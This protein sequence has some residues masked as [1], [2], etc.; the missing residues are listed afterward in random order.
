MSA[1]PGQD[2]A[3]GDT[4]GSMEFS[5]GGEEADAFFPVKVAFVGVG[6]M[7]GL[8]VFLGR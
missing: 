3:P 2:G 5:V 8:E 7:M 1:S 6:S 4:S